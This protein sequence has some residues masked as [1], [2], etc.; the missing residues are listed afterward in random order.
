MGFTAPESPCQRTKWKRLQ[1]EPRTES[2]S[3]SE[4]EAQT[5]AE[6]GCDC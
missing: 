6:Y 2:E 3:E 5:E 1:P 4:S